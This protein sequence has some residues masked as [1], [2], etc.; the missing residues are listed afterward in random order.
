MQICFL[1]LITVFQRTPEG[2]FTQSI[3]KIEN[4]V[5][6]YIWKTSLPEANQ[7]QRSKSKQSRLVNE[8]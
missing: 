5:N 7:N 2:A 6:R 1:A 8:L 4:Q 3:A